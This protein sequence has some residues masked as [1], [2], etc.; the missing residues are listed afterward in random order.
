ME[1]RPADAPPAEGVPRMDQGP[2]IGFRYC[3]PGRRVGLFHNPTDPPAEAQLPSDA[4]PPGSTQ[5]H[6]N[7]TA[8]PHVLSDPTTALRLES[9]DACSGGCPEVSTN[10][11][12]PSPCFDDGYLARSSGCQGSASPP[13][14]LRHNLIRR[15]PTALQ[16]YAEYQAPPR[17]T[18]GAT[19]PSPC[20]SCNADCDPE[21]PLLIWAIGSSFTN[22]LGNGDFLVELLRAW[23]P[24]APQIQTSILWS[25]G[26][27]CGRSVGRIEVGR[28]YS[29]ELQLKEFC[30]HRR[31]AAF[32]WL[33]LLSTHPASAADVGNRLAWVDDPCNPYYVGLDAPEARHAPVDRPAGRRGGHGAVDRRHA[34]HGAL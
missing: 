16:G 30:M 6:R 29:L 23:F 33:C 11:G 2:V 34:E 18:N 31:L 1:S 17:P 27:G 13:G 20:R 25:D 21:R 10:D 3:E 5:L 7:H 32:V 8:Q 22:G 9:A 15:Y 4:F 28:P 14:W 12:G 24:N 26:V 19:W